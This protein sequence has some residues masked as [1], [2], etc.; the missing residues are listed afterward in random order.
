MQWVVTTGRTIEEA[1]EAALD[2]LGVDEADADFEVLEEP[3]RGIFGIGGT[4]ARVRARV[5]PRIPRP[6]KGRRQRRLPDGQ[7]GV[8]GGGG[9]E[10]PVDEGG[11]AVA[12]DLAEQAAVAEEFV[13]GLIRAF[14][15]D[16]TVAASVVDDQTLE[17]AVDG[18]GLGVLIG[19]R[20][21]TLQAL[22]E[23][24]RAVVARR[25]G[26]Q[27]G[28]VVV[29]VAGYRQRR[30]EALERFT[31]Q[32]AAEV[33]ATGVRKALEPM[34]PA[35]RKVVHDVVNTIPGVTTVSEGDEPRRRVV[36][37]PERG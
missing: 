29:D 16:A 36:I 2:Q 18:S 35:D 5:R 10:G 33:L 3:R 9:L 13:A 19:P 21:Q 37:V 14:G 15:L 8:D 32:L 27:T 30:R 17:V 4:E 31:R 1:K 7:G 6:K 26:G 11:G 25:A 23:V 20:G 28:Q 34:G 12:D 24:V 22:T